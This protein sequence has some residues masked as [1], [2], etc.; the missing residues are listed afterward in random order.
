[1][2]TVEL[3][4][5]LVGAGLRGQ[6]QYRTSFLLETVAV[7]IGTLTDFVAILILFG[8]FAHIG[9]WSMPEVAL[10]YGMVAVS[11]SMAQFVGSGFEEFDDVV[12]KGTFDQVLVKPLGA[13][14]QI[15][16]TQL[17]LRRLGRFLQ[18]AM[19]LVLSLYWLDV[20]SRWG[21]GRFLFFGW[22]LFGGALFFQGLFFLRAATCFWSVES[23][24]VTNMLTYGGHEM[25]SYPM[26]IFGTWLRR[27]FIYFVPLAFVNYFPALYLLDKPDPLGG[28]P[29]LAFLAVPICAGACLVG[30]AIWSL[31]VRH[32]QSTGS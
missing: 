2:A 13:T 23:L 6:M 1:M 29:V 24:E 20:G 16:A 5:R 12:R 17:P 32:Y 19:I 25:A 22:T 31:G 10:L 4:V 26:H 28:P 7:F 18:G 15:V 30:F 8:R 9:G 11:F 27:V 14:F 3:Y 21:V